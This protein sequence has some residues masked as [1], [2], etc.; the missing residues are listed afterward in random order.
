AINLE[1]F[2][3][4]L[5]GVTENFDEPVADSIEQFTPYR[6]E[7]IQVVIATSQYLPTREATQKLHRFFEKIHPYMDRPETLNQWNR[8]QFDNFKFIV[9]ELYLYT[10][11]ILIKDEHFGLAAELI[12]TPYYVS[13]HGESGKP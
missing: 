12:S 2:R 8:F 10:I 4:T 11:A 7:F 5:D 1:R 3:I 9:H 13:W 6:N